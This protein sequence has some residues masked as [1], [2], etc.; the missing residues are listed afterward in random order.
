MSNFICKPIVYLQTSNQN[1]PQVLEIG[2]PGRTRTADPVINSQ[3]D[4]LDYSKSYIRFL[5]ISSP[6]D[7]DYYQLLRT[8]VCRIFAGF[9][10]WKRIVL[11]G[12]FASVAA[13]THAD[14]WIN[15][16]GFAW[17][18]RPGYNG[19]NPG[20]GIRQ[21]I[22]QRSFVMAGEYKNS[23]DDITDYAGAG[24]S[25]L[26]KGWFSAGVIGG[27]MRGYP[28]L[29]HGRWTPALLPFAGAEY[30]RVGADLVFIPPAYKN[31]V[32]AVGLNFR[33][34]VWP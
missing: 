5:Q 18:N 13:C 22:G 29:N 30:K 12:I 19:I 21:S 16:G 24:Y 6:F 27:T 2:S 26:K 20:F 31:G 32:T 28:A 17:H 3:R 8:Y 33:L 23:F 1:K 11:A 15:L 14:T 9:N 25:I 10:A 4:I 34:R 7:Y